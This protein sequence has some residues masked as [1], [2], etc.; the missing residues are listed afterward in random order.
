MEEIIVGEVMRHG[1]L[2]GDSMEAYLILERALC[3][4][5]PDAGLDLC[6]WDDEAP[7]EEPG[8]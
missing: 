4:C 6:G 5:D 1:D 7:N 3:T 8:D 2:H